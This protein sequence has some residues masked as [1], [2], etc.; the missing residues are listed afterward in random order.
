[1]GWARREGKHRGVGRHGGG[2]AEDGEEVSEPPVRASGGDRGGEE[3]VC[4]PPPRHGWGDE[5]RGHV[6]SGGGGD[7]VD[8]L[9]AGVPRSDQRNLSVSLKVNEPRP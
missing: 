4:P 3:T 2:L 6:A 8:A 7:V 9:A 5:G 1:V